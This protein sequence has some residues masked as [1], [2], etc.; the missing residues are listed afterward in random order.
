MQPFCREL[1]RYMRLVSDNV[2]REHTAAFEPHFPGSLVTEWQ[3]EELRFVCPF[4]L[5]WMFDEREDGRRNS[6]QQ[7]PSWQQGMPLLPMIT[8][9]VTGDGNCLP[10]SVLIADS[11]LPKPQESF[12][13]T[14]EDL[15]KVADLSKVVTAQRHPVFG[16]VQKESR[17]EVSQAC[18]DYRALSVASTLRL[19]ALVCHQQLAHQR[20]VL[21]RLL[22]QAAVGVVPAPDHDDAAA[23]Y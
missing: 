11:T 14:S 20:F 10:Q 21:P 3:P 8:F 5:V 15:L 16:T 2:T 23:A 6:N 13:W 22:V 7:L 19:R 12:V 17:V 4:A 9:G 18:K 1:V